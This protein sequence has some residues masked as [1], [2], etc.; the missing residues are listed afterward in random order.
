MDASLVFLVTCLLFLVNGIASGTVLSR[1]FQNKDNDMEDKLVL[2][3]QRENVFNMVRETP[4]L[5][6][7]FQEECVKGTYPPKKGSTVP[8]YKINLDLPPEQRWNELAKDKNKEMKKLVGTIKNLLIQFP[9][10]D[11]LVD[12]MDNYLGDLTDTLPDPF[13]KE[14]KG[15]SAASGLPLGE[16]VLYNIFYE[17]FTVCTSIIAEDPS[18]N[19]F[20]ARN[21]DFGLFLGWDVKNHTW[22]VTEALRP[23][24]VNLDWTNGGKTVFK[25]VNFAGY[26]GVF[27]AIKPQMFTLT[28]NERFNIEGGFLGIIEWLMG[29]RNEQWMGF[30]TRNTM[31]Y[32]TS[33][34]EAKSKLSD[35]PM[36]APAYF[37][38]GGNKSGEGC[39]ITRSG[40]KA[41]DIWDL[42][43]K[44]SSWYLVET[45][46]DHWEP[47]MFIDDRRTPA[48][49]C[50]E[51][52][53]QKNV[54]FPGMFDV[55]SSRPVLNKLTTYTALMEVSK[56]TLETYIQNCQD[57]CWAW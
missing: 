17:V 31:Q 57:P 35:T 9:K 34:S 13:G 32:A 18:G 38:L 3:R 44:N 2:K 55:L 40:S 46:Y 11:L 37:I 30:L 50:L 4:T 7:P 25:S 52:K 10:G 47:P 15:I 41:V 29:M 28:M 36:L 54:G 51:N 49:K 42:G 56:G 8:N 27:S 16:T 33:Y 45:N 5:P 12:F 23:L 24:I 14:I 6:P 39:I 26:V 20:H 48:K 43:T 19:L 22:L 1:N 53:G 21:L